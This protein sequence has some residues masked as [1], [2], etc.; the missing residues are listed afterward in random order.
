MVKKIFYFIGIN[1]IGM[2]GLAEILVKKGH[3]V[4]GSDISP[5]L[6]VDHF[7]SLGI[8]V[9]KTQEKTN[10]KSKDWTVVISSAIKSSNEELMEAKK[11][12]CDIIKRGHLLADIANQFK[13]RI[14]VVGTHGKT[15]TTSLIISIYSELKDGPS[16]FVGGHLNGRAHAKL[17]SKATFITEL[18]ESDG[19]FLEFTPK[20]S[21]ITNI[22]HDHV[23]YY[24]SKK[25]VITAF[26]TFINKTISAN[27]K[28]ALNLDDPLSE[29][30]F[31]KYD[32]KSTFITFGI[33]NK[34]AQIRAENIQYSWQGATF[35]LFINENCVEEVK[36]SLFGQHNIYN[37]L[38]AISVAITDGLALKHILNALKN[39][40][41]VKRRLELKY[42]A[43][44]IML[45]DDYAH[46]PTEVITTLEGIY[47]S[48][49][50]HRIIA[51]F[52]PHRFSRLTNL[53]DGF[54]S[55]F[56]RSSQTYI[57]PVFSAGEN[58]NQY[59]T[60]LDLTNQINKNKGAA[61]YCETFEDVTQKLKDVLQPNDII[62]IMGAGNINTI[63]KDVISI[64]KKAG[65]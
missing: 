26:S 5:S 10:I 28:C 29:K 7:E 1:G 49:H 13:N 63:A 15:T 58:Q 33:E 32:K 16:Y 4:M 61:N 42:K 39:F 56:V 44:E 25:D 8:D 2:S 17:E 38:S 30:L 52:Q 31:K 43:N 57:V 62:I 3:T 51:I 24:K 35:D 27:G 19:S 47:K 41:G 36:L 48:Y 46:H 45:F 6:K 53:F 22:E 20:Y 11:L 59:K 50:N 37:A 54:S 34:K 9:N 65:A 21:I 40:N 18:D 55:A 60:G 12:G 23:D 64:I 14:S